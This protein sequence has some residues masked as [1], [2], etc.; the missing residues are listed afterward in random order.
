MDW[1]LFMKAAFIFM[2]NNL[3]FVS[4]ER[5]EVFVCSTIPGTAEPY[6]SKL[7]DRKYCGIPVV[8]RE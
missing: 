4:D 7:D 3:S 5:G 6:C 2:M 8:F 1:A